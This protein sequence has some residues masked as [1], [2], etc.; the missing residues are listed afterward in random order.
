MSLKKINALFKG[1][2]KILEID[3][4]EY[5]TYESFL[6]K[7][8]EEFEKTVTYQ[9]M[10][11]NSS[12]QFVILNADNYLKILNEDIPEGLKLF[13]SEFVKAEEPTIAN[14]E[15]DKIKVEKVEEEDDEDFVIEKANENEEI[16]NNDDNKE[17]E[18][19]EKVEIKEIKENQENEGNLNIIKIEEENENDE[20]KEEN[21]KNNINLDSFKSVVLRGKNDNNENLENKI[22]SFFDEKGD[23]K[24]TKNK[25]ILSSNLIKPEMFKEEKCSICNSS[26]KGVKYICCLCDNYNLCEECELYHNHP[27]FKYKMHFISNLFDTSNFIEK[28]YGFKLPVE[29]TGYTKL[30]RK[31][32]DLKIAPMTDVNFS[33]RPNKKIDIP[34]KIMNNSKEKINSSQFV[35]ICKN[36][37]NIFLSTYEN[38]KFSI[39]ASGEYILKIKCVAPERTCPKENIIIEI[40]SH[41]L[42]IKSSRRLCHEYKIEVNFDEE[43]DKINVELKNDDYIYCFTKEHKTIAA[44][45][46]KTNS[47]YK[48]KNILSSLFEHNWDKSKALKSLKRKK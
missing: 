48:I 3:L 11:M 37:K 26:L 29:S 13:I 35:I 12:E 43:D 15:T 40:Y 9:I 22:N 42:N 33:L 21:K 34:I 32:Y 47:E 1:Q 16:N 7:I 23:I 45:F 14:S 39:D 4:Q 38:E 28:V 10:A 31:E 41:E 25:Y 5:N 20:K 24:D 6:K 2:E 18:K 17:N 44:N 8:N 27:C 36:Q 30:F 19:E 46:L